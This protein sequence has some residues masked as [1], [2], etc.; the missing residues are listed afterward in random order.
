M[1][2]KPEGIVRQAKEIRN[3]N[4][5]ARVGFRMLVR[6]SSSNIVCPNPIQEYAATQE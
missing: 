3:E 1:C 2:A 4:N 6:Y 5:E